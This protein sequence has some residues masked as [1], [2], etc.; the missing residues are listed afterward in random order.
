MKFIFNGDRLSYVDIR[1]IDMATSVQTSVYSVSEDDSYGNL[2][3]YNGEE[4]A[5]TTNVPYLQN[6]HDYVWQVML[7]QRNLSGT[8]NLYDIPVCRGTVPFKTGGDTPSTILFV[9]SNLPIYEWGYNGND[10]TSYPTIKNDTVCAGM[11]IEVNGERRFIQSYKPRLSYNSKI[12]GQITLDSPFSSNPEGGDRYQIMSNYLISPQYYF[13]SRALPSL[14]LSVDYSRQEGRIL[15][16]LSLSVEGNYSQSNN[17]SIKYYTLTL[18]A[19]SGAV[20]DPSA[21]LYKLQETG[22]IFSQRIKYTF[23]DFLVGK[24]PWNFEDIINVN[25]RVICELVTQDNVVMA[26]YASMRIEGID[27]VAPSTRSY[28]WLPVNGYGCNYNLNSLSPA[29]VT[30]ISYRTNLDTNETVMLR[31]QERILDFKVSTKG[32]YQY[33]TIFYNKSTGRPYLQS[34]RHF[35]TK[36]NF[37]GYFI[38]A[39]IPNGDNAYKLTD[40]WKFI[41]DI[42]N[43]TVTQNL[44]RNMHLG[45]SKF[46]SVSSTGVNYMSGT[47]SGMIGNFNCCDHQY[48][49]DIA[50]VN[51]WRDFISQ[52]HPYLLKSQK[53]DVWVVNIVESPKVEYQ[54]DYYKIPTRFTFSWAECVNVNDVYIEYHENTLDD[55]IVYCSGDAPS[56]EDTYDKTTEDDYIYT[57]SNN[58]ASI[59]LYKGDY[60]NPRIPDKIEGY[61]VTRICATAFFMQNGVERVWLPNNLEIIE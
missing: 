26:S 6:G 34:I 49:D 44:D 37:D 48:H 35:E 2:P 14:S 16:E 32:N 7:A 41:C 56:E 30:T 50:L 38:S 25:Y 33:T 29:G 15:D 40:T 36:T 42:D 51:A 43:T 39:L 54:E 22:K 21:T 28:T 20:D 52:P 59:I 47:L 17:T 4:F 13:M 19:Y 8:D 57:I 18:Y 1:V 60:P 55:D 10:E 58:T 24:N 3:R 9:D 53:G 11:V 23:K 5:T 12:Y 61:P 31:G 45:Y 46:P 27:D